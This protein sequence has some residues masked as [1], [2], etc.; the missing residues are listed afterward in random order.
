MSGYTSVTLLAIS[1][2]AAAT[3]A[4]A[5][6]VAQSN[7]MSYQAAVARN[8][9]KVMENNAIL[10]ERQADYAGKV[11]LQNATTESL[12]GAARSAKIKTAYAANN[13]D[14]NTGSAVDVAVSQREI[15]KLNA[16]NVLSDAELRAYGYRSQAADFRYRAQGG[17]AQAG[18]DERAGSDALT[19]SYFK[20]GGTLLSGLS[21][22][23]RWGGA[24]GSVTTNSS[25]GNAAAGFPNYTPGNAPGWS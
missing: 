18:M 21:S 20:A 5:G 10:A 2:A 24:G 23:G 6:G 19:A 4:I 22:M 25:Q 1:A 12:K 8:Q 13:I 7:A 17:R 11:G 14:P 9:A 3:G 15:N 16:E